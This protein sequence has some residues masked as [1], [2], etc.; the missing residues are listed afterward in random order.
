MINERLLPVAL[1]AGVAAD[2]GLVSAAVAA[3]CVLLRSFFS[4][5]F[6]RAIFTHAPGNSEPPFYS[7]KEGEKY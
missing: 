1:R 5:F 4:V 6:V 3:I 2:R 7:V